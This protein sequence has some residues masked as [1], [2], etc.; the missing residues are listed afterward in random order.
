MIRAFVTKKKKK[1]IQKTAKKMAGQAP[2]DC[3]RNCGKEFTRVVYCQNPDTGNQVPDAYCKPEEKPMPD[4][5]YKCPPCR[6]AWVI[7]PVTGECEVMD[8]DNPACGPGRIRQKWACEID[9]VP[10]EDYMCG[11]KPTTDPGFAACTYPCTPWQKQ[12]A[13]E[14][15]NPPGSPYLCEIGA[16]G[17]DYHWVCPEVSEALCEPQRPAPGW[18]GT[19]CQMLPCDG[20]WYGPPTGVCYEVVDD[21]MGN[22]TRCGDGLQTDVACDK[23]GWCDPRIKPASVPCT[24][25]DTCQWFAT[26]WKPAGSSLLPAARLGRGTVNRGAF[27]R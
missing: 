5:P 4:S 25:T 10:S 27:R 1:R 20:K 26:P 3:E 2:P 24:R 23:E 11:D 19:A 13:P 7:R 16:S 22:P 21:K 9:G 17:Q 8:P 6:G 18:E 12:Y 14:C 15:K